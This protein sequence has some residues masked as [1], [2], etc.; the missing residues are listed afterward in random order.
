MFL[1]V[2]LCKHKNDFSSSS[3]HFQCKNESIF[4]LTICYLFGDSEEEEEEE[5]E[6]EGEDPALDSLSQ[7]IAFQV[8][9]PSL[10]FFW[11]SSQWGFSSF[12]ERFQ[13]SQSQPEQT[14]KGCQAAPASET[15][16][17][18]VSP[19][20]LQQA[21]M[22]HEEQR[23]RQV[24]EESSQASTSEEARKPRIKKSAYFSD[25]EEFSD[26]W[27]FGCAARDFFFF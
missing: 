5:S 27:K 15:W 12:L 26:W 20:P 2:V 21:K 7:A 18:D 11:F 3:R 16:L 8:S 22:E 13:T 19:L 17:D 6:E 10:F 25:E 23:R 1:V 9:V 24:V 14:L 4:V